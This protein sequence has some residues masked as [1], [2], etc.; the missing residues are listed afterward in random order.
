MHWVL[1][2][3]L[4]QTGLKVWTFLLSF[5]FVLKKLLEKDENDAELLISG[6]QGN[7][8]CLGCVVTPFG[9]FYLQLWRCL[10][11]LSRQMSSLWW[12]TLPVTRAE[13][14]RCSQI[15]WRSR[16]WFAK[17]LL[18][19]KAKHVKRLGHDDGRGG[20]GGGVGWGERKAHMTIVRQLSSLAHPTPG[21]TLIS[22]LSSLH[23]LHQNRS[24]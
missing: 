19:A 22:L 11:N 2:L 4:K 8:E 3:T 5:F 6:Q 14:K 15:Y 7:T 1:L 12:R 24:H 20:G 9:Y 23:P 18:V 21:S 16:F 13:I 10:L 17:W